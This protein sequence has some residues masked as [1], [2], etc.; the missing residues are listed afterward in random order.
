MSGSPEAEH[1]FDGCQWSVV[2]FQL[3]AVCNNL[4]LL[5]TFPKMVNCYMNLLIDANSQ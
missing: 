2:S 1:F 5:G 3:R 4:T